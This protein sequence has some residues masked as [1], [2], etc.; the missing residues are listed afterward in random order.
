[1]NSTASVLAPVRCLEIAGPGARRFAQAQFS[2]DLDALRAGHW[3]W[4]AWLTP[5]GRVRALMQ[6]A[7]PGDG[8]LLAILRGGDEAAIHDGLAR[9][10]LRVPA[11]LALHEFGG[12]AGGP[13][14]EHVV[15]HDADGIVLGMGSRSL[16]LAPAGA[17]AEP[18]AVAGA[19]WLREDITLGWPTLPSGE[20]EFLPPALGLERLG[21]VAFEKGCYPGQE[22]VARL[23]YR[24]GHK[25]RLYHLRGTT[26]L[27][28]ERLALAEGG[29]CRVLEVAPAEGLIDILA[30]APLGFGN[31]INVLQ[32]IFHVVSCFGA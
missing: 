20:P 17:A 27:P 4:N 19:A 5:Q 10:L 6:L 26:A 7:D 13:C 12:F 24:G 9:Y 18:D 14:P 1:M 16:R 32:H 25:L 28:K 31:E 29:H 3:Q 21:A 2:G 15:V 8:R 11:T 30:V 23:H 22:I